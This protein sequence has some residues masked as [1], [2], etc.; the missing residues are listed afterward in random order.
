MT[1]EKAFENQVKK[2]LEAEGCW[3]LK[4]WGGAAFTKAGIPDLLVCVNGFFV[5]VEVKSAKGK[6]TELQ[7]YQLEQITNAGGY[8]FILYPKDFDKF[9]ETI[10]QIK[11]RGDFSAMVT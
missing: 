2:F 10:R 5:A 8:G 9:K 11:K 1:S 6:P 3:F 7:K 4:Y